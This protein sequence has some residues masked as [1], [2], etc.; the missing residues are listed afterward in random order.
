MENSPVN[1][2]KDTDSEKKESKSKKKKAETLGLFAVEPKRSKEKPTKDPV[3]HFWDKPDKTE[4]STVES[5]VESEAAAPLEHL[6]E[7]EKQFV[8]REIVQAEQSADP[9]PDVAAIERFRNRIAVEGQDS[10][11]ALEETLAELEALPDAEDEPVDD[12]PHEFGE[13]TVLLN[14]VVEAAGSEDDPDSDEAT[15]IS[16]A[17]AA[18]TVA[19]G[20]SGAGVPPT[21]P[22]SGGG[23]GRPPHGPPPPSGPAGGAPFGAPHG[24]GAAGPGGPAGFN[25]APTAPAPTV[26]YHQARA[27]TAGAFLVGGIVGYLIGRRR[28]R[29][30]TEKRLL[31]VQKK[32]QKEVVN[33]QSQL[34]QKE[35]KIR[36]LAATK[37]Q[38]KPRSIIEK[39]PAPIAANPVERVIARVPEAPAVAATRLAPER[40]HT[41]SR[42][43]APEAHQLHGK[44]HAPEQIGHML[45]G[46]AEAINKSPVAAEKMEKAEKQSAPKLTVEKNIDTLNRAELMRISEKIIIDG[47]SLRQ[48]YESRLVGEK[49]L[50]RL[51]KEHLK[52]GDIKKALRREIV[53]R[54]IDFERDPGLRD[55]APQA[56]EPPKGGG[57]AA[58]LNDLLQNAELAVGEDEEE[59]AF[60]KARAAYEDQERTQQKNHRQLMDASLVGTILILFGLVIMLV[61][62]HS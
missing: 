7:P 26:E 59:V 31:P 35:A 22:P 13:E 4:A 55:H 46:A 12:A 24:P 20:A 6:S 45:V 36:T 53:E 48:I 3:E 54:E 61:I 15:G 18:T 56:A 19:A 42:T 51:V 62:N 38:E 28:G 39:A 23:S 60:L 41:D 5:S 50:R 32:L 10:D 58:T 37:V 21:S 1:I 14:E 29:I 9:E 8:E 11:T 30:K 43:P 17:A 40:S 25:A 2:D 44:R 57:R 52:G 27:N 34:Q 16:T 47:S 49:G 33:L